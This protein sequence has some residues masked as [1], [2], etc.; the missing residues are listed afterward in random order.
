MVDMNGKRRNALFI[1]LCCTLTLFRPQALAAHPHIFVESEAT[2]FFAAKR[3][4]GIGFTWYFDEMYS[5]LILFDYD[6]DADGAL[7]A[8]ELARCRK[9]LLARFRKDHFMVDLSLDEHPRK[10][11]HEEDF[12]ISLDEGGLVVDFLIPLEVPVTG[13]PLQMRFSV[14]DREYYTDVEYSG[15]YPLTV[16]NG[17]GLDVDYRIVEEPEKTYYYGQVTPRAFVI[18]LKRSSSP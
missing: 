7:N 13:K 12:E 11:D 3:L 2:L 18:T 1:L 9:D 16:L 17:D 15:T 8:E 5:S 4:L 10:V 6:L 14:Y